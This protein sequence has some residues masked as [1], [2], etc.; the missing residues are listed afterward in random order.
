[1]LRFCAFRHEILHNILCFREKGENP[2]SPAILVIVNY[3][4]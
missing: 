2:Y 4:M 3:V 1:M